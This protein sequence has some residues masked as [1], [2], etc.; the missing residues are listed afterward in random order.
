MVQVLA[1]EE[2]PMNFHECLWDSTAIIER[3]SG[4][5]IVWTVG[6]RWTRFVLHT[7]YTFC[8]KISN[9]SVS[10]MQRNFAR[11]IHLER[12]PSSAIM[13]TDTVQFAH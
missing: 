10:F 4:K 5:L 11:P 1:T 12:D 8:V 9:L 3:N 7:I 2:I 13:L 6:I